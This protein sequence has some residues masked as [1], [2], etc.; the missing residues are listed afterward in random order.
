MPGSTIRFHPAIA[1]LYDPVQVYFERYQAPPHRTWMADGLDG[2]V[3][4]IGV[5]TGAMVPYYAD[6]ADDGVEL[7]GAEPDPGTWRQAS[8]RVEDADV[9]MALHGARGESLHFDDGTF[10]HVLET[11]VF[12]SIPSLEAALVEIERVLAPG[13][14]FRFFDHVRS[15]GVV[16]RSQDLLTP[17]WRRI[18]GNC[19][20]NRE[21]EP[22]L[23]AHDGLEVVAC[24]RRSVGHW[25]VRE[26][27]L[28]RATVI[29][30]D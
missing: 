14:E 20:L 23:A 13:G 22:V 19:H 11:G 17:L 18:G 24:E 7:H 9:S 16:G 6:H 21:V 12:C 25:P 28:G 10:D 2:R 27:V 15:T 30:R 26:F 29:G 5:G 1:A 4:E 8:E 3:L